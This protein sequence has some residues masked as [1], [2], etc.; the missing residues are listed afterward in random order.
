M[1]AWKTRV[2]CAAL[3]AIG[4]AAMGSALAAG[5]SESQGQRLAHAAEHKDM[6]LVGFNNLQARSAYQPT[7][8]KQGDRYIAY[9]GHHGGSAVN[10]ATGQVEN[11]GTSIVDV[12]DP[13]HPV[14]LYHLKG[15]SGE[16]EAGG[17]QMVRTCSGA[18]LHRAN[19]ATDASKYFMLRATASSHEVYDITDPSNPQLVKVVVGNLGDTHKSFWECT[20]G[21]AYL[22]SDGTSLATAVPSFPAWRSTRITQIFNLSDPKNP[23]FIRNYGLAGQE[24]GST[25]PVPTG[26]HGMISAIELGRNRVYFGHGTG[27]NGIM[28]IVDRAKLLGAGCPFDPTNPTP[29]Q[30]NCPQV[31]RLDTS[32]T[33]GAHTTYPLLDQPIPE[34][35]KNTGSNIRDFV[36]L[37]NEAGGGSGNHTCTGNRQLTYFIDIE[38]ES[39]PMGIANFQVP[40]ASGDFCDR[41]GR[42]GSHASSESFTPLFYGKLIFVSWFNAGV[43]AIDIRDPFSPKEVGYFIPATTPDTDVRCTTINGEQVCKFVI[44]TNNVEVDD[45]GYIYI[46]DRANTGMHILELS[47][48]ARKIIE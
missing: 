4:S 27:S 7:I 38:T 33:M 23:V 44:Q 41:G 11:N 21:I 9:V 1:K 13:A 36:I 16:G 39:K 29:A 35:A 45:R 10:S 32:P 14:Y 48:D 15:P 3:A 17:A 5:Q 24:P 47:G 2:A 8:Q 31:G 28:Q 30:L 40:E 37:V 22:V 6:N 34:F 25:G 19:A 20:T 43:R 12:T 46:V 18:D 42:F 26:V